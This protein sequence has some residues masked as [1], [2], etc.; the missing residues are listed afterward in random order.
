MN[1]H[2][3]YAAYLD[4]EAQSTEKHEFFDGFIVAMVGGTLQHSGLKTQ[5]SVQVV[6]ALRGKGCRVYDADARVHIRATGLTTYPDLSVVCGPIERAPADSNALTNPIALFEVL[7]PHTAAYDRG[8]KVDHYCT[9]PSLR[10]VVFVDFRRP[11]ID[12]YTRT[13]AGDWLRRGFGL[14][15]PAAL[16]ALGIALDVAALY[17]DWE[18]KPAGR[19]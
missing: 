18:P 5:L 2:H 19:G 3:T 4:L 8:E 9:I 7:S 15:E 10:H 11:H 13:E 6:S 12:V 17:V 1:K 14:G 16:S